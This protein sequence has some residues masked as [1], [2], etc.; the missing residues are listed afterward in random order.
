M[1]IFVQAMEDQLTA[2]GLNIPLLGIP[3]SEEAG[4]LPSALDH[5]RGLLRE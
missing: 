5:L 1:G 4:N 3:E 2:A